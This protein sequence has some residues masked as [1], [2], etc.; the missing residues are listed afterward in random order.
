[1][2]PRVG[3]WV[4]DWA[5]AASAGRREGVWIVVMGE[6]EATGWDSV[7]TVGMLTSLLAESDDGCLCGVVIVVPVAAWLLAVEMLRVC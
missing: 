2:V 1:L 3:A 7:E 4:W 5:S 6:G